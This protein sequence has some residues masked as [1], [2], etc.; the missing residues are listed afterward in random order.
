M[1]MFILSLTLYCSLTFTIFWLVSNYP[2]TPT[3][4]LDVFINIFILILTGMLS[5]G[6]LYCLEQITSDE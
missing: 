6:L 5:F 2:L 1:P 3:S 4:I